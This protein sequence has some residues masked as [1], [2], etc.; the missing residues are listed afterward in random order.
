MCKKNI[1]TDRNGGPLLSLKS[2][3]LT[4]DQRDVHREMHGLTFTSMRHVD[5]KDLKLKIDEYNFDMWYI[6]TKFN[7]LAYIFNFSILNKDP[8]SN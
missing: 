1:R 4:N 3:H 2:I 5:D 8:V 7:Y 6:K